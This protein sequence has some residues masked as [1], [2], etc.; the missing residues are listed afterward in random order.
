MHFVV[1]FRTAL[2][3]LP[4]FLGIYR[5]SPWYSLTAR[6]KEILSLLHTQPTAQ[7]ILDFTSSNGSEY[8][9]FPLMWT[10]R[11]RYCKRKHRT[12]LT[13]DAIEMWDFDRGMLTISSR[14]T[15]M[16]AENSNRRNLLVAIVRPSHEAWADGCPAS[17]S[18]DI[19]VA[20][21]PPY[22]CCENGLIL[23]GEKLKISR[24]CKMGLSTSSIASGKRKTV[25]NSLLWSGWLETG[26][27]ELL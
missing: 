8:D 24:K 17:I 13:F 20:G 27:P 14:W 19:A 25:G 2:S 26:L 4:I 16:K 18:P 6:T 21:F 3:I 12:S 23:L 10:N 9:A 22:G 7:I 15:S 1:L 5:W 11:C